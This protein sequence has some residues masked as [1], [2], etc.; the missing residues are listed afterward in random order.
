[1]DGIVEDEASDVV[2]AEYGYR[3]FD[4]A[5]GAT[6]GVDNGKPGPVSSNTDLVKQAGERGRALL[7]FAAPNGL[8]ASRMPKM[9]RGTACRAPTGAIGYW[10]SLGEKGLS[11]V[12]VHHFDGA[13]RAVFR[14]LQD[15]LLR[16]GIGVLGFRLAVVVEDKHLG[17]DGFAHGVAHALIMV[18]RY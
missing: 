1:M 3:A 13:H 11:G 18:H 14:R 2:G 5:Q 6:A 7:L 12:C 4:L 15:I 8:S 10:L 9:D 17:G 16:V